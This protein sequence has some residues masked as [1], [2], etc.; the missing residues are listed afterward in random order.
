[1]PIGE[2]KGFV[3]VDQPLH[4][5]VPGRQVVQTLG[6]ITERRSIHDGRCARRESI[7]VGAEDL[8]R[9]RNVVADLKPRLLLIVVGDKQKHMPVDGG[10]THLFGK[11]NLKPQAP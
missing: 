11:R 8:L 6:G 5:V 1:M 4:P 9:L 10:R 3:D 2:V 7:H